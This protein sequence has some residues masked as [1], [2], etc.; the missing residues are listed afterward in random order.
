[1]GFKMSKYT[2]F[3]SIAGIMIL[4][5][6]G[7]AEQPIGNFE[8][9]RFIADGAHAYH[10][11][12][13]RTGK[14]Y[15]T[16][17]EADRL[18][19]F[20]QGLKLNGGDDIIVTMSSSGSERLARKRRESLNRAIPIG[21]ARVQIRHSPKFTRGTPQDNT[22][23]VKV[24][25]RNQVAVDCK[26]GGYSASDL[27]YRGPFPELNCANPSNLAR[28]AADKRDLIQ[29]RKLGPASAEPAAASVRRSRD[30]AVIRLPL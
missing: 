22:A 15:L 8:R 10:Y 30:G 2:R 24:I 29:P 12:H 5:L 20:L 7:C 6:A 16:S 27:T 18:S 26:R 3:F 4:F 13:F 23:L 28:M 11:V 17:T 21:P 19:A 25:R 9:A 1:M 14:A